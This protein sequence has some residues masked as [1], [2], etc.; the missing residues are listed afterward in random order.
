MEKRECLHNIVQSGICVEC[1]ISVQQREW[2][3]SHIFKGI[4]GDCYDQN[5]TGNDFAIRKEDNF[6]P[7]CGSTRPKEPQKRKLLWE[8]IHYARYGM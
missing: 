2:P 1:R 8:I 4:S 6:C 5:W 3:C 7:K